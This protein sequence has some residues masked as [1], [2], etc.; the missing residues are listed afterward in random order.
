VQ[1]QS[2]KEPDLAVVELDCQGLQ[3]QRSSDSSEEFFFQTNKQQYPVVT[4]TVTS[5]QLVG[6]GGGGFDNHF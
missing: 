4:V 2:L 1:H 5:L 6:V 3:L